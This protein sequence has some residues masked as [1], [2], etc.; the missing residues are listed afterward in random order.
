MKQNRF[1]IQSYPILKT[2]LIGFKHT[3]ENREKSGAGNQNLTEF[4]TNIVIGETLPLTPE[5]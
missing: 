2:P 1:M 3:Y 4:Q 5:I